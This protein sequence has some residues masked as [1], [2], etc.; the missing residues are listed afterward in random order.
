MR[1]FC[2]LPWDDPSREASNGWIGADANF[3]PAVVVSELT[4][5]EISLGYIFLPEKE[6]RAGSAGRTVAEERVR[7][8]GTGVYSG[9]GRSDERNWADGMFNND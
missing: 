4:H 9:T 6:N 1:D 3:C 2:A 5:W 8:A 7:V